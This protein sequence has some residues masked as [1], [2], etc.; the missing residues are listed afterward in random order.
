MGRRR[1]TSMR[2]KYVRE[3]EDRNGIVLF[4]FRRRHADSPFWRFDFELKGYR[5][6]GTSNVP[7]DRP[8]GEA[9]VYEEARRRAAEQLTADRE[10]MRPPRSWTR[11]ALRSVYEESS[12]AS[13]RS[14][15]GED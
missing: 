4:Y 2:L 15:A 9:I 5:F 13:A 11:S 10:K 3:F 12:N 14:T 6:A 1:M 8:K 7:K